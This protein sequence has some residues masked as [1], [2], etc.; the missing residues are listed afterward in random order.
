VTGTP[1]TVGFRPTKIAVS[2]DSKTA[3]VSNSIDEDVSV[4]N[5]ETLTVS[6]SIPAFSDG[7]SNPD[8]V[9]LLGGRRLYVTL[10][11]DGFGSRV[12]VFSATTPTLFAEIEV[13]EGPFAI[14]VAPAL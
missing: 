11:G 8:G 3:F 7:L 4:I 9:A 10:F 6:R 12:Q 5:L 1:L 2:P 13:G 14:A